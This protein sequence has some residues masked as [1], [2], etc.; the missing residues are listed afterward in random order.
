MF[1]LLPVL[2]AALLSCVLLTSPH[3]V[4]ATDVCGTTIGPGGTVKLDMNQFCN[5]NPAILNILELKI[6]HV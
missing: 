2:T 4:G 3:T 6:N 5:T 1:K